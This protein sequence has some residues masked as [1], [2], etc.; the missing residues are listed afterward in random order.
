MSKHSVQPPPGEH[1]H[2]SEDAVAYGKVVGVGV[3]SLGIFAISVAWAYMILSRETKQLV[4]KQ[5]E[6]KPMVVGRPEVGIIDQVPFSSD[7]RLEAWRKAH[8]ERLN[9]YG[10]V[11]KSKGVAHIPIDKAMDMIAAGA[12]PA[13]AP[14]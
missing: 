5:G 7:R 14:K 8:T 1:G 13:G 2:Q 4:E 6:P 9:G 3:A 12:S 10:W 11:D